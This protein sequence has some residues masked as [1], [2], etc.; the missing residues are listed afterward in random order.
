MSPFAHRIVVATAVAG[1]AAPKDFTSS[2][3]QGTAEQLAPFA[4]GMRTQRGHQNL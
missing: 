3:A 1:T 2:A 4:M